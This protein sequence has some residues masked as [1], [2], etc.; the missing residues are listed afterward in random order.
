M[1]DKGE[2]LKEPKVCEADVELESHVE[3]LDVFSLNAAADAGEFQNRKN[4]ELEKRLAESDI[5]VRAF[6]ARSTHS[7]FFSLGAGQSALDVRK[8][9][10][11]AEIAVLTAAHIV[12]RYCSSFSRFN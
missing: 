8:I 11:E 6:S 3:C 7:R 2:S 4:S 10:N 9:N 12:Q 1:I 5:Q